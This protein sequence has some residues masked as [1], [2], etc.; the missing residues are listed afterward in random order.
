MESETEFSSACNHVEIIWFCRLTIF[1]II[2]VGRREENSGDKVIM[3][4]LGK[5][6]S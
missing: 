1:V 3:E 5:G 4:S 6:K 2:F